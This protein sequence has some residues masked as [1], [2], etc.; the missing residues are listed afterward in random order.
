MK[1]QKRILS[2]FLTLLMVFTVVSVALIPTSAAAGDEPTLLGRYFSTDNVWYD[3]V[4]ASGS[5]LAWTSGDYPA[6]N[7]KLNMTYLNKI[8]LRITNTNLFSGVNSSTGVSFAFNYRPNVDSST[9]YRTILSV[10][11]NSDSRNHLFIAGARHWLGSNVDNQQGETTGCIPVVAWSD[12]N[13]NIQLAAYPA[14]ITPERGKEYNIVI[15]LD[16]DNGVVFYIDGE[17]I[18]ATY[19]FG[20]VA[21]VSSLLEQ[22]KNYGTNYI[23]QSRWTNNENLEAYL[24]DFR[25]YGSSLSDTQA[26]N[27]V[28]D[29][30]KATTVNLSQPI[31]NSPAYI[32]TNEASADAYN[33]LVYAQKDSTTFTAENVKAQELYYKWAYPSNIVMVYDGVNETYA[34]IQMQ[35]KRNTGLGVNNQTIYYAGILNNQTNIDFKD[36]WEGYADEEGDNWSRWFGNYTN[37]TKYASDSFSKVV[38]DNDANNSSAQS[39]TGTWRWWW[40]R[41]KY[42]GSGNTV[43]YYEYIP[44]INVQI[45]AGGNSKSTSDQTLNINYYVL[46]YKPVYD[47]LSAANTKYNNEMVGNDW[48]YT[49]DSYAQALLAMRRLTLCNPNLYDYDGRGVDA[50]AKLS[51]AA[52]KQA[53]ENYDNINLIKKQSTVTITPGTNTSITVNGT[54]Y[55]SQAT[56]TVDYGT[57]LNVSTNV[58]GELAAYTQHNSEIT[59]IVTGP[60]AHGENVADTPEITVTTNSIDHTQAAAVEENRNEATCTENG[61]YD[62]VVKCSVCGKELSRNSQTITSTG[63]KLEKHEYKAST[64]KEEGNLEYWYCTVCHKYFLNAEATNESSLEGV[65]LEKSTTH[66]WSNWA[67]GEDGKH[68]RSC[69]VCDTTESHDAAFTNWTD[70][71]DGNHTGT[72]SCGLTKKEAHDFGAWTDDENGQHTKACSKCDATE[73]AE[74]SWGDWEADEDT[75]THTREC[76]DC[77]ATETE[78][79]NWGDWTDSEDGNHTREC[80]KCDATETEEHNWSDWTEDADGKHT[81]EC[82]DCE[83]TETE[84]H[85]WD[86]WTKGADGKHTRNCLDCEATESHN[87]AFTWTASA[88]GTT[89]NA[90]CTAAEDCTITDSHDAAFENWTADEDEATHTGKCADCTLTETEAH[91]WENWT[92]DE[93]GMHNRECSKCEA[94]ESH[95]AAFADWTDDEDG[96]THTGTCDCGLTE[97]EEHVW[98][99]WTDD[100]D[101]EHHSKECSKCDAA[102]TAA[103][104]WGEWTE[105]ADGKHTRDCDDCE[106]TETHDA[107]FAGWED[108][109]NGKHT[110]KCTECTITKTEAHN[111]GEPVTENEVGATCT[112]PGSYDEVVYCTECK[113]ELSR[114]PKTGETTP[115]SYGAPEYVWSEDG[116]TCTATR[117]C[118]ECNVANETEKATITSAQTKAPTCQ[119]MGKTT[120]TATFTNSAFTAQEKTVADIPTVDHN[121]KDYTYNDDA[122]CQQPGTQTG[123]CEWC[124]EENTVL[125]PEHPQLEHSFG[126]WE[127][128]TPATCTQQGEETRQCET[129]DTVETRTIPTIAHT[130]G[131]VV[132]GD[133][134]DA[135]CTKEGFYFEVIYCTECDNLISSKKIVIEKKPHEDK[136]DDGKCDICGAGVEAVDDCL[137]HEASKNAFYN[138]IYKIFRFFWKLFKIKR[139]CE[140]GIYHY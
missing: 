29:M 30:A 105:V 69:S 34:P 81:R 9:T 14:G 20:G 2:M 71:G 23:G 117:T 74:H 68:T 107:A 27:L 102:E 99:A 103:H 41:I 126:E 83:A 115:H 95:K 96:T 37:S 63:H 86:D 76:E 73:E 56:I 93:N 55:T 66:T 26:Y 120:Y 124:D 42:Y 133:G 97:K 35:T 52:I 48:M 16:K 100:E 114:E 109:G 50:A 121:Y 79:H 54:N 85:N 7:S 39:N 136:N 94:T 15:S 101:G 24:S 139:V 67:E 110:G 92:A 70:N 40:N 129:C 104:K 31:F 36:N 137:C 17:K 25:I 127:V 18:E 43:D 61:S 33:N 21:T 10:G 19:K 91:G 32:T 4:T 47:I 84:D 53:K 3:T 59:S 65:T 51:A 90:T 98:D 113:A 106:A 116:K 122:T 128:T 88:D 49:E 135:T 119:E 138:F 6:Y 80:S 60:G 134:E 89:H 22:F 44:S 108:N 57:M 140:C 8:N 111:E 118:E 12:S 112:T 13:D 87:A 46:N 28:A 1:T 132:I 45:R 130:P 5:G 125:D 11:Q 58:A 62:S 38:G 82:E 78:A 72:C 77:E 123:K 64:C 75:D 131:D